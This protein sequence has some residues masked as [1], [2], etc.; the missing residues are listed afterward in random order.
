MH[1]STFWR[2]YGLCHNLSLIYCHSCLFAINL[3]V[4]TI[5][6]DMLEIWKEMNL[7]ILSEDFACLFSGLSSVE[8]DCPFGTVPYLRSK[9]KIMFVTGVSDPNTMGVG[10]QGSVI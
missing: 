8:G 6:R 1:K 9:E 10:G 5:V 7:R 2:V 4:A 3:V